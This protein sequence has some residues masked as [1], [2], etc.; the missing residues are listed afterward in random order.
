MTF[1]III[2]INSLSGI[3][4]KL[5]A[6]TSIST[7][8]APQGVCCINPGGWSNILRPSFSVSSLLFL[9]LLFFLLSLLRGLSAIKALKSWVLW[10]LGPGLGFF[11]LWVFYWLAL[12]IVFGYWRP[13]TLEVVLIGVASIGA[14]PKGGFGFGIDGFFDYFFK[15]IKLSAAMLY[16]DLHW[17]LETLP[18]ILNYCIF[19]WCILWVKFNQERL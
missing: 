7:G 4:L 6:S 10:F 2:V 9:L 19:L 3:F 5:F 18:E 16:F 11:D 13:T 15:A 12:G 1:L 8:V 17:R 14:R